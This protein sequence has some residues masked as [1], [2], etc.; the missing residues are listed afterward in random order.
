MSP[1]NYQE[2]LILQK[3]QIQSSN[4]PEFWCAGLQLEFVSAFMIMQLNM[5][6][7]G[8]NSTNQ[9]QVHEK[10][11][12]IPTYSRKDSKDHVNNSSYLIDVPQNI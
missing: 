4:T 9:F 7:R 3:V 12:R 1:K 5:F 11:C 6:L 2:L 10:L 8:D